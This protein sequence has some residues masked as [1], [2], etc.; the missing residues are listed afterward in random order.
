MPYPLTQWQQ[1]QHNDHS[2]THGCVR[3]F[4]TKNAT[5]TTNKGSVGITGLTPKTTYY[6]RVGARATGATA[7]NFSPQIKITTP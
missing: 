4:D 7:F 6:V 1:N 3:I 2:L 5:V